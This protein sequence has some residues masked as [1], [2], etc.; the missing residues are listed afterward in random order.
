MAR[1]FPNNHSSRFPSLWDDTDPF[2]TMFQGFPR[3]LGNLH[4]SDWPQDLIH[5]HTGP[6]FRAGLG[7]PSPTQR[8]NQA[9][10][11]SDLTERAGS[12]PIPV[13]HEDATGAPGSP[14][15]APSG[16][17]SAQ[18]GS[19][20]HDQ[21]EDR[22]VP[23]EASALE[24]Q[25]EA[26]E[27]YKAM[28]NTE[29]EM[30][31]AYGAHQQHKVAS[32]HDLQYTERI[33]PIQI[34]ST[35][36]RHPDKEPEKNLSGAGVPQDVANVPIH[37]MRGPSVPCVMEP[38]HSNPTV[39]SWSQKPSVPPV[40]FLKSSPGR[41]H[42]T[43]PEN[44]NVQHGVEP[45]SNTSNVPV[46]TVRGSSVRRH[47][48]DPEIFG[49]PNHTTHQSKASN[50]PIQVTAA[51]CAQERV[52]EQTRDV[53]DVPTQVKE[54]PPVPPAADTDNYAASGGE[55]S[56]EEGP[57]SMEEPMC[58]CRVTDSGEAVAGSSATDDVKARNSMEMIAN[59]DEKV[60]QLAEEVNAF[61]GK[62]GDKCYLR[63]EELLTK[64][65][66]R[67]DSIDPQG[68][69]EIRQARRHEVCHVHA[70]LEWLETKAREH[71]RATTDT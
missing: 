18:T 35:D 27:G 28:G 7:T 11:M 40:R 16:W 4:G 46:Q 33:V 57:S 21:R 44:R 70:V 55:K 34:L 69:V 68:S 25:D 49:E 54:V 67:L 3:R 23:E 63:L 65:L 58:K 41:R 12:I 36:S 48:T 20:G 14:S 59:V 10:Q 45:G 47:V 15:G 60:N 32:P 38:N 13:I 29:V 37:V 31:K 1:R 66:L 52:E 53:P 8:E 50:A 62:E 71:T 42:V 19:T 51:P 30:P 64:E 26:N 6:R 9:E 39:T 5:R 56:S 61:R 24:H 17:S 22:D 2:G 43:D